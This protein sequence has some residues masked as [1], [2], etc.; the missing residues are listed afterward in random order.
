MDLMRRLDVPLESGPRTYLRNR[1][2]HYGIDTS[3]FVDEALPARIP[4]SYTRER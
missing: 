2:A 3:H 1:L 4:Q